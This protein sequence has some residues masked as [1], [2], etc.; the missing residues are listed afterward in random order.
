M[1]GYVNKHNC[2]IWD[3][4]NPH[5]IQERSMHPE[6]VLFG[7]GAGSVIG[8]YFFENDVQAVTSTASAMV[9]DYQLIL[10]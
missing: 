8:P 7:V 4:T 5:E 3:D 6:K 1:N 2:R 9:D 10:A